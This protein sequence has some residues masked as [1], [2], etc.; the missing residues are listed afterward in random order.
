MNVAFDIDGVL[1]DFGPYFLKFLNLPPHPPKDWE[2]P[3]FVQNFWKIA[4]NPDFWRNIPPII[5]GRSIIVNPVAY[6]TA[7]P[8]SSDVTAHWLYQHGFPYAPVV[9]V[10]Y[11]QSKINAL[12]AHDVEV[13]LDDAI[14]NYVDCWQNDITC[15]LA[16]RS[17]NE[18]YDCHGYRV[19]DVNDF[20]S[21]L[22]DNKIVTI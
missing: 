15:Y 10:G 8:I 9:T 22:I 20:Q 2:D 17:H 11:G 3:R 4:N 13:F 6:V 19:K 14:H 1:A 18:Q 5:D 12:K 21:K 7:R 16:S